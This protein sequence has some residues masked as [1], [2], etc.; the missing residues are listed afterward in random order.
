M[1]MVRSLLSYFN[2]LVKLWME[3]LKIAVH[4]LNRA[5]SKTVP[6]A[7]YELWIGRKLSLNYL[8]VWGCAAEAKIFNPHVGKLDS[9]Q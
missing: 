8:H 9:K 6:K 1:D 2:L 7:P 4:I 5:P 3:A